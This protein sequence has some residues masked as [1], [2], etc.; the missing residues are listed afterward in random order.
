MLQVIL[1]YAI[2]ASSFPL[3]KILLSYSEPF[4][5][6]GIRMIVGG[7]ILLIYHIA[8]KKNSVTISKNQYLLYAQ[9][10]FIG[11]YLNYIARFW[12][13]NYLSSAKA[14]CIFAINPLIA[15]LFSYLFLGETTSK[16][17]W[18]G[19]AFGMCSLIPIFLPFAITES[20]RL[21]TF[22]FSEPEWIMLFSVIADCYKWILIR[23]L[24]LYHTCSPIMVNGLSMTISG[25]LAL[26]TA[27]SV[28]GY[29]PVSSLIPFVGYMGLYIL[30]SNVI[31]YNLY[32][33]LL[34]SYTVTFM[35]LAGF[36]APLFASFYGWFFLK[37]ELHTNFFL[38]VAILAAGLYLFYQ[39]EITQKN[40]YKE[41][42]MSTLRS[43]H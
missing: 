33:F 24:I 42:Q 34:R 15:S 35:S 28:E 13:I 6:T 17:Q 8:Y 37:E 18:L 26:L 10:I 36:M 20:L 29:S 5:M 9:I 14:S 16:K 4:F 3:T 31:S 23:K 22:M 25:I 21:R 19:F 1:M 2:F 40:P 30:I 7:M 41:A 32:S 43:L 11:F 27:F 12:S 39:D 38:S